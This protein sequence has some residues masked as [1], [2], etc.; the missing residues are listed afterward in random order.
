MSGVVLMRRVLDES[1]DF[2]VQDEVD[3]SRLPLGIRRFIEF[4]GVKRATEAVQVA[5]KRLL[6]NCT[7]GSEP[8]LPINIEN[9]CRCLGVRLTGAPLAERAS[10][11]YRASMHRTRIVPSGFLRIEKSGPVVHIPD[12]ID[13]ATARLSVAHELGHALICWR[14]G[15]FDEA[16]ARLS[17]EP[18]EEALAEYAARLL[19]LPMQMWRGYDP[20]FNLAEYALTQSRIARVTVH[21]AV[22]RLGDPDLHQINVEGAIFWRIRPDSKEFMPIHERLSPFWH[23]CPRAFIPIRKSKAR[24]GSLISNLA[25]MSGAVHGWR[26]EDVRIGTFIGVYRVD[27]CAWGSVSEGSRVVL[28]VFRL[29]A[30]AVN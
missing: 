13:Y 23:V 30:E 26:E 8:G 7:G 20:S 9:L 24:Q 6:E 21:S 12:E 22:T 17:A 2:V 5:T 25:E 15:K 10:P 19:L 3:A 27:A 1:L 18:H 11:S 16:V 29:P 28:S 14:D 4:L